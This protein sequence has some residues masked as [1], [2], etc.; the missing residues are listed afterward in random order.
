VKKE[1]R[2]K[3]WREYLVLRKERMQSTEERRK[4]KECRTQNSDV[5]MQT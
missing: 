5:K 3:R 4:K 2:R 1:G